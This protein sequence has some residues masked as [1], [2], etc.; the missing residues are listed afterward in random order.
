LFMD[1]VPQRY[2]E[3]Q[4]TITITEKTWV[5]RIEQWRAEH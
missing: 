4:L 5:I 2:A 3:R 1:G